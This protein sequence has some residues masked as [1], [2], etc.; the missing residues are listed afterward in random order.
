LRVDDPFISIGQRERDMVRSCAALLILLAANAA[1]A[2]SEPDPL[3]AFS[4]PAQMS[5]Y[6]DML[7]RL[8]VAVEKTSGDH[9]ATYKAVGLRLFGC[10]HVYVRLAKQAKLDAA[11]RARYSASGELYAHA[12]A[13]LYPESLAEL[14]EDYANSLQ[15]S[16]GQRSGF[17]S[18]SACDAFSDVNFDAVYNGVRDLAP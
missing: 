8:K 12:A 18:V 2:Q 15:K 1:Q 11:D 4:N 14:R 16:N 5:V 6:F 13:G 3:A 17:Y 9:A 7:A 10:S